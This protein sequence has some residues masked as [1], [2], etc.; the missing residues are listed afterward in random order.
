MAG[1]AL[2]PGSRPQYRRMCGPGSTSGWVG[3]H[4]DEGGDKGFSE[5]KLGKRITFE[6]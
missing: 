5:G 3:E 2:G 1:E 4:G 6:M